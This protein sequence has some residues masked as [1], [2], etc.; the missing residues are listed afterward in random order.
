MKRVLVCACAFA[1]SLAASAGSSAGMRT[2]RED[3]SRPRPVATPAMPQRFVEE[4]VDAELGAV[5]AVRGRDRSVFVAARE[6]RVVQHDGSRAYA[7]AMEF[8]GARDDAKLEPAALHSAV[9]N[10]LKGP[11]AAWRTGL[12]T[13][14]ALTTASAWPG[15]DVR[16]ETGDGRAKYAFVVEPGAD[17]AQVRLRWRGAESVRVAAS[18]EVIV[19][20]PLGEIRDARPAAWT[21]SDG[22]RTPVD[23]R[24]ALDPDAPVATFALGAYDESAT[25]VIDPAVVVSSGFL[26][27][28]GDEDAGLC[29]ATDAA[30]AAYVGGYTESTD[31]PTTVGV[32]Q[33]AIAGPPDAEGNYSADGFVA[34]VRPDGSGFVYVTFLGGSASDQVRGIAVDG[35]G[36]AAVGGVTSSTETTFPVAVGPDLTANGGGDAFVGRLSP[37]GSALD[38]CGFVGGSGFETVHAVGEDA[39][40]AVYLC[41]ETNT[42][43]ATFP[44]LVG[45]DLTYNG[46]FTD[47]FVV[48]VKSD[49]SA[50]EYAGYVGG[51]G[52]D[53]GFGM[54]VTPGGAAVL[55]GKTTTTDASFPVAGALDSTPNGQDDGWVARVKADGTALDLC[56]FVGG[57]KSE[58]LYDADV[59]ADGN[60]YVCGYSYSDQTTFPVTVGPDLTWAGQEDGVIAKISPA[61]VIQFCG[62]IGGDEN[63]EEATGVEVDAQNRP[64]VV[65]YT[66]SSEVFDGF[67]VLVG[68]DLTFNGDTDAWAATVAADGLGFASVGYV[69]GAD[70]DRAVGVAVSPTGAVWMAGATNSTQAT[71][72]TLGG[73]D[74]TQNGATDTFVARFSDTAEALVVIDSFIAPTSVKAK[75]DDATPAK[76][77]LT[78]VGNLDVGTNDLDPAGETR[79]TIGGSTY[80]FDNLGL[81]AKGKG[82]VLSNDELA[83][84]VKFS[85]RG[86]SASAFKLSLT[87]DLAGIAD[88]EGTLTLRFENGGVDATATIELT[89]GAYKPA[90][91][92]GSLALPGLYVQAVAATVKGPGKDTLAVRAGFATD[93]TTPTDASEVEVSFGGTL[94]QTIDAASFTKNGA[95]WEYRAAPGG[96]TLLV[97]DYAKQTITLQAKKA[98]LGAFDA[99]RNPVELRVRI[100]DDSRAVR[101]LV[102]KRGSALGY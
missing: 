95:K 40:G 94:H 100:G 99:A 15:I 77:R 6:L 74:V 58:G 11:R 23:A 79:V 46:G 72:P 61:G 85:P 26:G 31:F 51:T 101:V 28:A 81:D 37:D 91:P 22:R 17:P 48:K 60:I 16:W 44:V 20:T 41:G 25:L 18:G 36:R 68:P 12:R 49:G 66:T 55:V 82:F 87:R 75:F 35:E 3:V 98:D 62:Y 4:S 21:E 2:A 92:P 88:P 97:L 13:A 29:I 84:K 38:W 67:P 24:W 76:S 10:R 65:G 33:P 43:E 71:F 59:D 45:P 39:A 78:A 56:G 52:R 42:T 96:I 32:V 93:G 27:G 14:R 7:A 50:I 57:S 19:T 80:T 8:V 30:G 86:G 83:L 9:V 89:G 5:W 70:S 90:T 34:K 63:N 47:A 102:G 54:S 73:P 64:V 1:L 53:F 69:G